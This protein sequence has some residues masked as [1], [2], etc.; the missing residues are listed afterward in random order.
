MSAEPWLNW[1][2]DSVGRITG[3]DSGDA[4]T[5]SLPPGSPRSSPDPLL[6]E[7]PPSRRCPASPGVPDG[8]GAPAHRRLAHRDAFPVDEP[9]GAAGLDAALEHALG[10]MAGDGL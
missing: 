3:I 9:P 4:E 2:G 6:D 10:G 8:G 1:A 5:R 7:T